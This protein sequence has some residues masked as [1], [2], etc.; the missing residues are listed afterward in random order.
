[1]YRCRYARGSEIPRFRG[2]L[3]HPCT[4]ECT[5][6]SNPDSGFRTRVY[7]FSGTTISSHTPSSGNSPISGTAGVEPAPRDRLHE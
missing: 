5:R 3:P 2:S 4:P 6:T 7:P 1:M